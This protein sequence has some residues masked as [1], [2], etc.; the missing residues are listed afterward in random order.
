MRVTLT[1]VIEVDPDAF[2]PL[3]CDLIEP[4]AL[5]VAI[6]GLRRDLPGLLSARDAHDWRGSHA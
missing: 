6:N 1:I 3:P 2:R 5:Q 4:L